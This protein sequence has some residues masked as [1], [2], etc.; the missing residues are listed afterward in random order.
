M[1]RG[2]LLAWATVAVFALGS[3]AAAS[4]AVKP[5]PVG[6]IDCNG[7]S[8]IQVELRVTAACADIRGIR[9]QRFYDNGWYIGHDEPAIRLISDKPMSSADITFVER[10]PREP[11]RLP[12]VE[13]PGHDVTHTF[14]LTIAPWF[15]MSL[16][17]PN[18]FPQRPCEP[19]S[20]RN[21]PSAENPGGGA[22]FLE[23]Q[24]YAPGFAPFPDNISCDNS[25]WCSALN[26]DSLECRTSGACNNDCVEPVNF[27]WIQNNGVPT[28]PPSPQ[29]GN[30]ETVTP[31]EHTLLMNPGD[32][33]VVHMFD[34]TL[35]D[36]R[37]AL[38]VTER[39]LTNGRSGFM[40]ASARNGFM[41]TSPENCT[42]TRFNFQP[43]YSSAAP[44]N[45]LPW[46]AGPYNVDT[47]FEVGHFEP[48]SSLS[49]RQ[50]MSQPFVD[51][52]Y[53]R[54]HG[55]YEAST[56]QGDLE[57]NDAPCYPAGDTHGGLAPPNQVTG[58]DVF[59]NAIGDLEYDGTPYWPDWPTSAQPGRFP[60]AFVQAQPTTRGS[61]YP[62]I[63]FET[64]LAATEVGCNTETG[65]GCTVPPP[66]PGHFYPYWTLAHDTTLGCSWEFGNVRGGETFGGEAQYG[67]VGP[68]TMAAFVSPILRNPSCTARGSAHH[69]T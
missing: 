62:G 27:A 17:D 13:R 56:D 32:V 44:A 39:D 40:V 68:T 34:A 15:S 35:P 63:Q 42:G 6:Q 3:G 21:A 33:I 48:C 10:L 8:R 24:F 49:D 12:T 38:E 28:G 5:G 60:G 45:I 7:F 29:L 58:C 50:E 52:F 25:H 46:G 51:V 2:V 16:C 36:H 54:C 64:D 19:V 53:N 4:A 20:D 61:T 55:P 9:G 43:E 47:E 14:E 66:G 22:A 57:P 41:N 26:I 65:A 11:A 1:R 59:N 23:L 69:A 18:S 37:R 31:N 30:L 67:A